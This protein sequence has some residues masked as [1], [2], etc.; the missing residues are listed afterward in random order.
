MYLALY[1]LHHLLLFPFYFNFIILK[2][3]FLWLYPGVPVVGPGA[4]KPS[5]GDGI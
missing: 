4:L 1:L 3:L 5:V 2:F